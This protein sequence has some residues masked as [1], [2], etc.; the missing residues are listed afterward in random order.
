M[1]WPA[2]QVQ[3]RPAWP[4]LPPISAQRSSLRRSTVGYRWQS[5]RRIRPLATIWLWPCD[6][7]RLPRI[8][9]QQA[10]LVSSDTFLN[11][12]DSEALIDAVRRC[13]AS[14]WTDRAVIYRATASIDQRE[15]RLAVVVQK[16]I[17]AVT[18]GV[19]F[20]ANPLTGRRR[21]AVIE[22]S[23][24]LGEAVV[25]GAVNP[26][27]FVVDTASGSIISERQGEGGNPCN[28]VCLTLAQIRELVQIGARVEAHFG[29]PQDIEFAFDTNG[30]AHLIQSRPIT[31]LYP[32]PEGAN[33]DDLR[34]YMS[35]TADEGVIRPITPMG[36]QA[37]RVLTG[38]WAEFFFGIKPGDRTAGPAAVVEAGMRTYYDVTPIL[39]SAL[40]RRLG[41]R[42]MSFFDAHTAALLRALDADLRLTPSGGSLTVLR[43][44]VLPVIRTGIFFHLIAALLNPSRVRRANR[45]TIDAILFGHEATASDS[46]KAILDRVE[47][48]LW[49]G[50]RALP[51]AALFEPVAGA[52]AQGLAEFFL[53][54]RASAEELQIAMQGLPGSTTVAMTIDL[55]SLA[56]SIRGDGKI[57]ELMHK[58][59]PDAL[60]SAYREKQLPAPLQAGL[61]SYL[62]RYGHR[63]VAEVDLGL[64]R[65][66]EDPG[67]L[68]DA[69]ASYLRFPM[70]RFTPDEARRRAVDDGEA[71][72]AKL[73]KRGGTLRRAAVGWLL[74][75]ARIL[76]GL[77][78]HWKDDLTKIWARARILLLL[79]G[80]DLA[81][82]GRLEAAEDIFFVSLPEAR[83]AL[84]GTDLNL[85]TLV[86]D[87]RAKYSAELKRRRVPAILLSDGTEPLVDVETSVAGDSDLVLNGTAAS[88]GKAM[89]RA[90]VLHEPSGARL[91]PGEV[92]VAPSTD[93]GWT[94]LFITAAG[95]VM[96]K[97]GAMSHG[98]V[99]AREYG[100]P[101]VVG[102]AG[103]LERIRTGD[104][105]E[106]DGVSGRVT[107]IESVR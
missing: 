86:R 54:R 55:W 4:P 70:G 43:L 105:I 101:A 80:K 78:E 24:G 34:V 11:V 28:A 41:R 85:R 94:P 9:L 33:E 90:R 19:L 18:A 77:R 16:M 45:A 48:L 106:V 65:W 37:F 14:L 102:V 39:R 63:T 49:S 42:F 36:M 95:L 67:F 35:A 71:M 66:S 89:G 22:V 17:H 10:S 1:R 75:R 26:D 87:R 97:G 40:A 6:H 52:I 92:L 44:L 30:Q 103:A 5:S 27:Q 98:A 29:A 20:T 88:P 60:S 46:S 12:R 38:A 74:R 58:S 100:I 64:A 50:A 3:T 47:E 96:E 2:Q 68:F 57:V 15:V 84:L 104:L 32:L 81:S 7:R 76:M 83:A 107:H 56:V 51:V 13:W 25:S 59:S 23:E 72:A 69:L 79:V 62:E 21:Q 82:A 31:T 73:A 93:P 53:S 61:S 91:E 99:I 8:L